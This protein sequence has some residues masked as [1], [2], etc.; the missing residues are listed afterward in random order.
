MR[1]WQF[2]EATS[3]LEE[4]KVAMEVF[5]SEPEEEES[6]DAGKGAQKAKAKAKGKGGAQQLKEK[7]DSLQQMI[8]L[9]AEEVHALPDLDF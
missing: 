2:Q 3:E 5:D 1:R 4:I 9:H 6:A 7:I 8:A